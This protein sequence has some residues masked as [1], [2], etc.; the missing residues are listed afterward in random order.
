MPSRPAFSVS[1]ETAAER[2]EGDAKRE[3]GLAETI[4]LGRMHFRRA[5]VA[6]IGTG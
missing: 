1:N 3:S 2:D 5:R 6:P 4:A